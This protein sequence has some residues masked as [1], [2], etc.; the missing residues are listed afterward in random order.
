MPIMYV[1]AGG[2]RNGDYY[3]TPKLV[4]IMLVKFTFAASTLRLNAIICDV[5][6][7]GTDPSI[8]AK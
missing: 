7:P 8:E 5:L 6:P 3:T 2:A 1:L 4:S